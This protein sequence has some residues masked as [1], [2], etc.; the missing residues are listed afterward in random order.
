MRFKVCW[1]LT[2]V[3]CRGGC[4][5]R[6]VWRSNPNSLYQTWANVLPLKGTYTINTGDMVQVWS[7]DQFVAPLHRVLASGGADRFSALSSTTRRDFRLRR[8][9]GNVTDKGKEIQIGDFK[10]HGHVDVANS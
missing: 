7:N 1:L 8:Y 9:Q 3:V 10:I 4:A 2:V 5:R 6:G